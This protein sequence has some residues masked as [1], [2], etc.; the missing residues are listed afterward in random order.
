ME[1]NLPEIV[2]ASSNTTESKRISRWVSS[3]RLRK[4]IPRVYTSNSTDADE[5]IISRNLYPILSKL[6]PGA[7]LSHRT[8]LEGRPTDTCD[9]FL[10]YKYSRKVTLPGICVHLLKGPGR[11]DDDTPFL[12]GL[13]MSSRPR[14]FIESL[15][16]SRKRSGAVKT[17]PAKAIEERLD[18]I[19]Q[20]QGTEALNQLRDKA[21]TVADVL[22]ME[23]QFEKLNGMISAILRTRPAS[24]LSSIQAR[25][26]SLG[27]PYDPQRLE[28]F[29]RLFARLAQTPMAARKENRISSEESRFMAFFEAYFSN[30]IEGT[31]F[32]IAEAY[33]IVFKHKIPAKRPQ[34]AHDI[35]GTF[36]VVSNLEEMLRMPK[37]F[38]EFLALLQSRHHATMGGRPDKQPGEFKQ[39]PNRAG[40]THFV[41][42]ELVKGTLLKGFEM[43]GAVDPG[44]ARAIFMMFLVAEVHPFVDGN[45]RVARIMMNAE[46]ISH[47]FCRILMPTVLRDDYL[48][49]LRA[50]SRG[51]NPEPLFKVMDF[52]QRF[53]SELSLFSYEDTTRL[54]AECNA[55]KGSDEARLLLPSSLH[56]TGSTI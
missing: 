22:N 27:V 50:L 28:I 39:D 47:G 6:F 55:F 33:D 51:K 3:G 1:E 5:A 40:A 8:A 21:R 18:R 46:L 11:I 53:S 10:T 52:A 14:A 34:D 45:G 30:Y 24:G 36:T 16:I 12:Q 49:A 38:D 42:P 19:C 44:L 15:Q 4:I 2:F 31:E 9:V 32:E 35:L 26:R 41:A 17:L 25:A 37:S 48:L 7:L 29:N 13:F 43:Y 23:R 20:I 54:L 56:G